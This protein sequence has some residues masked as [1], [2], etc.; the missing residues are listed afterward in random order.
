MFNYTPGVSKQNF[1]CK[2]FV[3]HSLF[4]HCLHIQIFREF[5]E[6]FKL[7]DK[8][9]QVKK[10]SPD[11]AEISQ[12]LLQQG[13]PV[14]RQQPSWLLVANALPLI[15]LLCTSAMLPFSRQFPVLFISNIM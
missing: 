13:P 9:T 8:L 6:Y 15:T 11:F 2:Y 1:H 5:L 10:L 4:D 12:C 14:L 3:F 7:T